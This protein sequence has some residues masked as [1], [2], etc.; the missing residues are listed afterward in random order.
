MTTQPKKGD[1]VNIQ[2]YA[3]TFNNNKMYD[4]ISSNKNSIH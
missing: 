2:L 1:T 3:A 4:Y